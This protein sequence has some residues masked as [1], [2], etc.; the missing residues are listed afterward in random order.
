MCKLYAYFS[1]RHGHNNDFPRV[2][3]FFLIIMYHLQ[4]GKCICVDERIIYSVC[5]LFTLCM[6]KHAR[7][8]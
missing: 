3:I 5:A 8:K 6:T 2:L 4:K 7:L 1:H